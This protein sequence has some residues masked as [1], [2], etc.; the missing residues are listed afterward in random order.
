MRTLGEQ[1]Q[2]GVRTGQP[3]RKSS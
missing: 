1:R 3:G 2:D